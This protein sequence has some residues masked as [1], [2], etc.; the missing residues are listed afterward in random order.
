MSTPDQLK[1][2]AKLSLLLF[3][4]TSTAQYQDHRTVRITW[5]E[6]MTKQMAQ[7]IYHHHLR[8][9]QA[10]MKVKLFVKLCA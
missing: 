3:E 2:E 1:A 6:G 8:L 10:T 5:T 4:A 9:I 7:S